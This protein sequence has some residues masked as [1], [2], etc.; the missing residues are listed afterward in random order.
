[1]R[2]GGGCAD[3]SG[4]CGS[5]KAA[6]LCGSYSGYMATNCCN[7][8]SGVLSSYIKEDPAHEKWTDDMYVQKMNEELKNMKKN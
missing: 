3:I 5:W 7:S 4:S 2:V 8:C 6:G 1:V